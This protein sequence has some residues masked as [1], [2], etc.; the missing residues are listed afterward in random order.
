MNSNSV[1]VHDANA[2][3]QVDDDDGDYELWDGSRDDVVKC[4]IHSMSLLTV[5][6]LSTMPMHCQVLAETA[7]RLRTRNHYSFQFV[8]CI[9]M[10]HAN[11]RHL[12][13][14]SLSS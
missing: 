4:S 9:V 12:K 10:R 3:M 1:D 11:R 6:C 8:H 2:T 7:D 13:F 14:L 5:D